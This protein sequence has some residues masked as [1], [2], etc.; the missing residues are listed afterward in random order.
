MKGNEFTINTETGEIFLQ[1]SQIVNE[2]SRK[3]GQNIYKTISY[4]INEVEEIP[5]K[6]YFHYKNDKLRTVCILIEY[7]FIKENYEIPQ[8]IDFRNYIEDYVNHNK[9]L[10]EKLLYSLIQKTKRK[11]SW[12]KIKIEYDPRDIYFFISIQYY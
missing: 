2:E 1:N 9:N 6:L 8:E 3:Y 7:S 11:Y 10:Y 12:G 5:C 4:A